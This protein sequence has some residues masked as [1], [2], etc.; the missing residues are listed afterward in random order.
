MFRAL[1]LLVLFASTAAPAQQMFKC[2]Q[3]DGTI[4]Y[5]QLACSGSAQ[6]QELKIHAPPPP[7]P[8]QTRRMVQAFDPETG[9]PTEAWIDG[10]APPSGPTYTT[11]EFRTV[12]DPRTGIP[13]RAL[14]DMQHAVPVPAPA[15]TRRQ[16]LQFSQPGQYYAPEPQERAGNSTYEKAKCRVARC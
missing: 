5:Q 1:V 6:K 4:S 11:R 9:V 16:G 15:P 8:V 7:T 3:P 13:R 12:V 14:V 10:P 2:K